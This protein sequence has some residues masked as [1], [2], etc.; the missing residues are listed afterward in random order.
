V[1]T[2]WSADCAQGFVGNLLGQLGAPL[3]G[4][5]GGAFGNQGLAA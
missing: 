5:I 3:G 2:E 1:C 4:V